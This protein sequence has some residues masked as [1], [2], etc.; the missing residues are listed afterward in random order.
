MT[1]RQ[2]TMIG[3]APCCLMATMPAQAEAIFDGT[4]RPDTQGLMLNGHV[5]IGAEYGQQRGANLFHSFERFN[6]NTG[7]S[8]TFTGPN[9][10]GN[11]ISRVTGGHASNI[12]GPL[13]STI[14]NADVY[15]INPA[16][17]MFGPNASLDVLGSF[18]ASTADTLRL[19]NGGEFNARQPSNSLLTV[20]PVEAFGFLTNTPAAITLQDSQLS[21]SKGKTLSLI[22]GGLHMSGKLPTIEF[23]PLFNNNS[24]FSSTISAE[25]GRINFAS[26]ASQ[27]EVNPTESGLNLSS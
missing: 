24:E 12:D 7:E 20:A 27:G 21:V 23:D 9:S 17:L 5:E 3:L 26:V 15:L 13:R 4:M 10:I 11:I 1:F 2:C 22:G 25:F 19:G 16:G 8:A 14:S 6:I 18:H